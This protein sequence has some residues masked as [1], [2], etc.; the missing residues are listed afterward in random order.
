MH[1]FLLVTSGPDKGH[2]Y[3]ISDAFTT[4]FGRSRHANTKLSDNS[5]SRVHCEIEI[6]GKRILLTDLESSSGTFVN[7][8]KIDECEFKDGDVLRIGNTEMKLEKLTAEEEHTIAPTVPPIPPRPVIRSSEKL[9]GLAGTQLSHYDVGEVLAKGQTGLIFKAYDFKKDRDVAMKVLW[10]EFSQI[11]DD[12]QRFIRAMKTMMPLRHPNL[13]ALY[14]AGKT[15]PYCWIS[16]ENVPGES[17]TQIIARLGTADRLDWR[18]VLVIGY[19][20]AKALEYAHGKD[21]I[22]R[23]LTPQNVIVG[24]KPSETKLGD[25]MLAKAQEGEFAQQITKPGEILGDVR[26]LSPERTG[27]FDVKTVDNRSDLYSLGALM[28]AMLTGRPPFEGTNLIDTMTKI[29]H[30]EP[31]RI[32]QFQMAVNESLESLVLKLLSKRPEKRCQTATEL[33]KEMERTAKFNGVAL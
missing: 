13:V 23:N 14:G 11:E 28:Y 25:L 6:R 22:H 10:P 33:I 19:Y 12:M 7:N 1:R 9:Q 27:V 24:K 29:V 4:L 16:M 21:I 18:R 32:K 8:K 20:L 2:R 15:G 30:S 5:I 31:A 3:Q 17:L 26:Y